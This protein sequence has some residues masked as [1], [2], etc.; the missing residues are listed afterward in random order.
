MDVVKR[1]HEL[2]SDELDLNWTNHVFEAVLVSQGWVAMTTLKPGMKVDET[3]AFQG[4]DV[5]LE[6]IQLQ[7][8]PDESPL[9]YRSN[10]GGFVVIASKQSMD[11]WVNRYIINAKAQLQ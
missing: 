3:I 1:A 2:S 11:K 9:A 6:L 8:K 7:I 5:P 4:L 10:S